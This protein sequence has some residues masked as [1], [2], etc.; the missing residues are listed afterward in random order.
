MH[1]GTFL[2][3]FLSVL[4]LIAGSDTPTYRA[5]VQMV[6]VAFKVDD[7]GRPVDNIRSADVVVLEDGVEQQID[8]F[9]QSRASEKERPARVP[10]SVFL[11]VDTSNSMYRGYAYAYDAI[12]DFLRKLDPE[13]KA[14]VYTF[15]RNLFRATPLTRDRYE[16]MAGLQKSVTGE[17]TALYDSL[18]LTLRDAA[19]VPGPKQIVVF[20]NGPDNRSIIAPD[21]VARVAEDEGIPVSVV[22]TAV[23]DVYSGAIWSRI[24]QKS[25]GE[26][27][28]AKD[29]T[30][31]RSGFDRIAQAVRNTY[32]LTYYSSSSKPGFRTVQVRV[33]DGRY[34]VRCRSGYVPQE[35]AG[36]RWTLASHQANASN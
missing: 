34:D 1:R 36:K 2:T 11:L 25:G 29:W 27:Y 18:L 21:D 20:S 33:K 5:D 31:T 12:A 35:T 6:T 32:T 15:S 23:T 14:A 10:I 16:A 30:E 24:A 4:P 17:D 8:S 7:K 22:S 9:V 3:L 19:K 26:T 13:D 28:L